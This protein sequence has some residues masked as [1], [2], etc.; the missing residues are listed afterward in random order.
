MKGRLPLLLYSFHPATLPIVS[1]SSRDSAPDDRGMP[2]ARLLVELP[3]VSASSRDSAPD[4]LAADRGTGGTPGAMPGARLLVELLE[5][6]L[7]V[8]RERP[9]AQPPL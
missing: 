5:E 2:G 1:A 7:A 8:L 3:I 4:A 6:L 9:P